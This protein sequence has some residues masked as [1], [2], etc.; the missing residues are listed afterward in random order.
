[1]K[2]ALGYLYTIFSQF[3]TFIFDNITFDIDG[4]IVSIGW[5]FVAIFV[6]NVL[7]RNLLMLPKKSMH[8]NIRSKDD[9]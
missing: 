9:D 2:T 1:M 5:L 6:F 4:H 3:M 8:F 7:I